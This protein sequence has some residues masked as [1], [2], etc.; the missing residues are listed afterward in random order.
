MEHSFLRI[1][2]N[3]TFVSMA[4]IFSGGKGY[5]SAHICRPK[6]AADLKVKEDEHEKQVDWI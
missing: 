1:Y 5:N 2:K 3:F 4:G 6:P